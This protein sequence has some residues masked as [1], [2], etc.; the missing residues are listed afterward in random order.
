MALFRY[1]ARCVTNKCTG[2]PNKGPLYIALHT[3]H[4]LPLELAPALQTH[5]RKDLG[6]YAALHEG[7]VARVTRLTLRIS[8]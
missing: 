4:A 3:L 8:I 7:S 2:H 5:L 1:P 6:G